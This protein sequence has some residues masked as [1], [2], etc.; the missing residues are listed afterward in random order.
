MFDFL[1]I[2]EEN[3]QYKIYF[4][5]GEQKVNLV[6]LSEMLKAEPNIEN[7]WINRFSAQLDK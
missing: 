6:E 1:R 7:D 5:T 4:E 3:Q 2:F